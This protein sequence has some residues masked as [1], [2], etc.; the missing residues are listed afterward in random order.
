MTAAQWVGLSLWQEYFNN[1]GFERWN[2]IYSDS[3]EVNKVQEDIRYVQNS[4]GA[5]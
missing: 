4:K 2:K 3:A 5:A 1:Q